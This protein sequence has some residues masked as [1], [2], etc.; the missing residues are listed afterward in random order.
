[1][2]GLDPIN[3]QDGLVAWTIQEARQLSGKDF[4]PNKPDAKSK[5]L[6][7]SLAAEA[8]QTISRVVNPARHGHESETQT[9]RSIPQIVVK[10]EQDTYAEPQNTPSVSLVDPAKANSPLLK[11]IVKPDIYTA[12]IDRN[13]AIDLRWILR[14]IRNNR[15]KLSPVDQRDLDEL[16]EL[17]LV[18]MGDNVPVLTRVGVAAIG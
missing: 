16:M 8:L 10:P 9:E 13:R 15:L 12:P 6:L 14:D 2:T 17:G 5:K 3:S 11:A 1:M 18:E 4:K 7:G